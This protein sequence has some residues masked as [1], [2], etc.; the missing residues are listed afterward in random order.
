MS[1]R[2]F[3]WASHF[4][5]YSDY[6]RAVR[7][8]KALT[9]YICACLALVLLCLCSQVAWE[10]ATARGADAQRV[11]V[12]APPIQTPLTS[13]LATAPART[14]RPTPTPEPTPTPTPTPTPEPTLQIIGE[15]PVFEDF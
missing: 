3:D 8:G 7:K 14:S 9:A 12:A 13:P 10:D 6:L 4:D 5:S 11:Q 2:K 15:V 1:W